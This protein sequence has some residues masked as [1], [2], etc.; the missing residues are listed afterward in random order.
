MRDITGASDSRVRRSSLRNQQA[1]VASERPCPVSS[2]TSPSVVYRLRST[3]T[4]SVHG[5]SM[6]TKS[7]RKVVVP[8]ARARASQRARVLW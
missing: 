2:Q 1:R 5:E 6:A 7:E 8:S 4:A 3:T